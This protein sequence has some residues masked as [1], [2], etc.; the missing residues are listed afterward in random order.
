MAGR[1][2]VAACGIYFPDQGWTHASCMGSTEAQ[3]PDHQGSPSPHLFSS[4]LNYSPGL[5]VPESESVV[6]QVLPG[7]LGVYCRRAVYS[8]ITVLF[9]FLNA[10]LWGPSSCL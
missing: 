1:I 3:P 5:L 6:S 8:P 2:L 4:L 9:F 7:S 10:E